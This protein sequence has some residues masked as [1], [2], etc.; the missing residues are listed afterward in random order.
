[1]IILLVSACGQ[2][3]DDLIKSKYRELGWIELK[4]E[5]EAPVREGSLEIFEEDWSTDGYG[6]GAGLYSG[7]P[8]QSYSVG[9]VSELDGKSIRVPGFIVP[10]EFEPGNLIT[11]F[12][13]VPY[14]GACF[15]KPPPSTK[16]N[17]I[18][19]Q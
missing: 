15:H 9:V 11:E 1:M 18:R 6:Q 2:S 19:Y 8:Q 13:L 16:S 7:A 5:D 10:I 12:F 17:D 14:F 3:E 4:P